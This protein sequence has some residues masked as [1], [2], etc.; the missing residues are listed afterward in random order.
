V[1]SYSHYFIDGFLFKFSNPRTR[2]MMA[3]LLLSKPRS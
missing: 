3:P 2:Q 1:A